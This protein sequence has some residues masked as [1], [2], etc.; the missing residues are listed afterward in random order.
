MLV[1]LVSIML[2]GTMIILAVGFAA[3]IYFKDT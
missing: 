1:S 3:R 2:I